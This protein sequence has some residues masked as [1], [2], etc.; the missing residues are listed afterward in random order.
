MADVNLT[1]SEELRDAIKILA[2]KLKTTIRELTDLA[3]EKVIE[4]NKCK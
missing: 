2:V 1:T 3:L 4:E